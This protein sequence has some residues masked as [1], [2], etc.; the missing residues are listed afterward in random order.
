MLRLGMEAHSA[1]AQ[2]FQC[3]LLQ[4]RH[5]APPLQ[6]DPRLDAR[7][8]AIAERNRVPVRL[9]LLDLVAVAEPGEDALLRLILCQ[10]GELTGRVVHPSVRADH[11][12]LGKVVVETDL[13]VRR[14]VCR[15]DLECSRSEVA[16]DALVG[17]HRNVTLDPRHDD[18]T[19]DRVPVALVVGMDRDGHVAQ[20][21]RRTDRRDR[22]VPVPVGERVADVR[23]RVVDV[24]VRELEVGEGGQVV[25]APVPDPVRTVDPALVPEMYEEAHHRPDVG[26]VHREALA[27]VVERRADAA[28]L[29]HDLAAVLA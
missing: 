11:S 13:V 29:E 21:R 25:W 27:A 26:V 5:R 10:P 28:E 6:R 3:G 8:A 22:D 17:D 24:L 23:Q 15:R 7:L 12:Q 20:D 9:A 18:L 16:L 19:A 14:V 4:L 2:G 1:R